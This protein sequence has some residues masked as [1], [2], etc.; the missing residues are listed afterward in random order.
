MVVE[1]VEEEK[2]AKMNQMVRQM[3][4]NLFVDMDNDFF[5][6]SCGLLQGGSKNKKMDLGFCSFFSGLLLNQPANVIR[7]TSILGNM[8]SLPCYF[9]ASSSP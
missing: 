4:E 3:E 7:H 6:V 2:G 8:M 5:L 9:S 1:V